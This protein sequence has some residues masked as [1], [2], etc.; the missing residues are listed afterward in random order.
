MAGH[1]CPDRDLGTDVVHVCAAGTSTSSCIGAAVLLSEGFAWQLGCIASD[2]HCY[3]RQLLFQHLSLV[4]IG[5]HP[6]VDCKYLP[7][8]FSQISSV[9]HQANFSRNIGALRRAQSRS[10]SRSR[11]AFGLT[12]VR[13]Y[14]QYI[15]ISL[16]PCNVDACTKKHMPFGLP[17]G[18]TGLLSSQ[19]TIK[20][21]QYTMR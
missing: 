3:L 19:K 13:R 14:L 8:P 4:C 11:K 16:P 18:C 12:H 5:Q 20:S 10:T 9:M 17:R 6:A 1:F 15:L 7:R 21:G 2:P